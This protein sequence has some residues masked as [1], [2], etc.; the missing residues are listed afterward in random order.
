[1]GSCAE[2]NNI[3]SFDPFNINLFILKGDHF[4]TLMKLAQLAQLSPSNKPEAL[5]GFA[6][7]LA[8]KRRQ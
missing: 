3:A 6:T 2:Y 5:D 4:L 1:M 8:P 7:G